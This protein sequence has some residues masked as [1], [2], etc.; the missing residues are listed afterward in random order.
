V[1]LTSNEERSI[2]LF[3]FECS[4]CFAREDAMKNVLCSLILL[5]LVFLTVKLLGPDK[6]S[7]KAGETHLHTDSVVGESERHPEPAISTPTEVMHIHQVKTHPKTEI[8]EDEALSE[9]NQSPDLHLYKS[10][11]S[12]PANADD[13]IIQDALVHI[14]LSGLVRP[15]RCLN[16]S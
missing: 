6:I 14:V 12:I 16:L 9:A 4:V 8:Q 7:S 5:A 2:R 3:V 13:S 1:Y 15:N 10:L 11:Y